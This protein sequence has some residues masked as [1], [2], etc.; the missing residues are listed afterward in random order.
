MSN[1]ASRFI[2]AGCL[3]ELKSPPSTAPNQSVRE[4]Q[5]NRKTDLHFPFSCFPISLFP[6]FPIPWHP[7]LQTGTE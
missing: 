1:L 7:A 6:Y 3:A 2:L 4:A 5:L